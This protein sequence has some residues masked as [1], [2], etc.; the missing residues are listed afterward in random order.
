MPDDK[1]VNA[2]AEVS[3]PEL[4]SLNP[5]VLKE[6]QEKHGIEV[7]IRSNSKA[8]D[9]ILGHLRRRTVGAASISGARAPSTGC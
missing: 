8:I 3:L 7:S 6:L 1:K 5:E 4:Q 2:A 9:Q